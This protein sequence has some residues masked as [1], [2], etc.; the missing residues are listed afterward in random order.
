M[1]SMFERVYP[2]AALLRVGPVGPST[3]HCHMISISPKKEKH[4]TKRAAELSSSFIP[5]SGIPV[6]IYKYNIYIYIPFNIPVFI[7][8]L[9][10][11]DS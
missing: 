7:L 10:L 5:V 9:T 4:K 3:F 2:L 6:C 11:M 8:T 1:A